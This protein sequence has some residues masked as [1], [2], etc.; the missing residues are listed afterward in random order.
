MGNMLEAIAGAVE[1]AHPTIKVTAAE[2]RAGHKATRWA[3]DA[4]IGAVV[5]A[6]D[7]RVSY[8]TGLHAVWRLVTMAETHGDD[9]TDR[10]FVPHREDVERLLVSHT[11]LDARAVGELLPAVVA[12]YVQYLQR[13]L[14]LER[15]DLEG[16]REAIGAESQEVA[17]AGDMV[18]LTTI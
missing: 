11:G 15:L 17:N 18:D 7:H 8:E 6:L 4:V 14:T 10:V 16:L 3:L 1:R 9:L 5:E 12:V 13:R 2:G